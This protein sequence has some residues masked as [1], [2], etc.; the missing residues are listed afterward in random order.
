MS[1]VL[2]FPRVPENPDH[3]RGADRRS[4]RRGGRRAEDKPGYAPL[5]LLID[6]NAG[7]GIPCEAIL[8]RLRFAVAP[9]RT[10][11]EAIRIMQVLRP[12]IVVARVAEAAALRQATAADVPVVLLNDDL[13][14][15]DA[16]VGEI[17]RELQ[18][19]QR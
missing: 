9:A 12:N 16:L 15:P 11:D 10:I 5:V 19:R 17:R 13:M 4:Q 2:A 6:E 18:S 3:R 1:N 7:D 14:D 8:S